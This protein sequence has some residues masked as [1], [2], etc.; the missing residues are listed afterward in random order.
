MAGVMVRGIGIDAV[1]ISEIEALCHNEGGGR[2]PLSDPFVTYAFTDG[3]ISEARARAHTFESLAG[4]FA[5]KEAAFK[6]VAHLTPQS[7]FDLR[8]VETRHMRDGAP[9]VI[10]GGQLRSILSDAGVT[11]LLVSITNEGD[12]AIAVVLAQ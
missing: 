2:D 10:V 11:E 9:K 8:L 12:L 4:F 7:T 6:A 5:V 3:E 1:S